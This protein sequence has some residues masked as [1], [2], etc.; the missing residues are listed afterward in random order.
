M[1]Q[2][3]D[4]DP[5]IDPDRAFD[6]V[7][8]V[9][10]AWDK[11][12]MVTHVATELAQILGVPV[13]TQAQLDEAI[14][15]AEA[16]RPSVRK[17]MGPAPAAVAK[18]A[19]AP[20]YYG[21]ALDGELEGA[22]VPFKLEDWLDGVFG[23]RRPSL[24]ETLKSE[25]RVE[26]HPHV[27]VVHEKETAPAAEKKDGA[28]KKQQQAQA[29]AELDDA[30]K[31]EL[32][33]KRALWADCAQLVTAAGGAIA[34]ADSSNA[35]RVTLGPRIA[36]TDKVI[37]VEV[38]ALS[39]VHAD[40]VTDDDEGQSA[41]KRRAVLEDEASG[42]RAHHVTV[43]TAG[44]GVRPVEGKLLMERVREGTNTQ[45]VTIVEVSPVTVLGTLRGLK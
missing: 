30:S 8:Q 32:E 37:S 38:S 16:Y 20:R 2:L 17:D 40:Q 11:R 31:Q 21:V 7:I 22:T 14:A 23:E 1:G 39:F 27:T 12:E 10:V 13:P 19:M 29:L 35:V 36:C 33:A 4:F 5:S 6:N 24:Y 41:S 25:G 44:E 45:D 18:K 42:R 43:G 28:T 9:N 26:Q 3:E 34:S 15:T